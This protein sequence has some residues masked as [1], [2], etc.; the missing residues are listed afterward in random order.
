MKA[1]VKEIQRQEMRGLRRDPCV[2]QTLP[3]QGGLSM[4]LCPIALAFGCKKCPMFAICPAKGIIG[5]YKEDKE[6]AATET[7]NRDR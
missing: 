5:D 4:T 6:K 3:Q 2:R 7:K 1:R